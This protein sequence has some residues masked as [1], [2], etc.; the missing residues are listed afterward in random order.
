MKFEWPARSEMTPSDLKKWQGLVARLKWFV[1]ELTSASYRQSVPPSSPWDIP[2]FILPVADQGAAVYLNL[3]SLS[4]TNQLPDFLLP[5]ANTYLA[6]L[7]KYFSSLGPDG[8]WKKP[9]WKPLTCLSRF[10]PD[11]T[12]EEWDIIA[13]QLPHISVE[14]PDKIAFWENPA[15]MLAGVETRTTIGKYARRRLGWEDALDKLNNI[16][17]QE[18]SAVSSRVKFVD[19]DDLVGW[20]EVYRSESI[21]SCMNNPSH[22]VTEHDTYKCY[23]TSAHDL[24]D[25][26]LRLAWLLHPSDRENRKK[27][28][29]RA[30]VHDPTKAYV[31]VY[32]DDALTAGLEDLGYSLS[33]SWPE[34]LEL[35]AEGLDGDSDGRYSHPYIDGCLQRAEF[36]HLASGVGVWTLDSDGAYDLGHPDGS[37]NPTAAECSFCGSHM[38]D[39]H[40]AWDG[41]AEIE[42]CSGCYDNHP[43]AYYLGSHLLVLAD[44][45]SVV[46]NGEDYIND[47]RNLDYYDIV[48]SGYEDTYVFREDCAFVGS[49]GDYVYEEHL[50][51]ISYAVDYEVEDKVSDFEDILVRYSDLTDWTFGGVTYVIPVEGL[52]DEIDEAIA[53]FKAEITETEATEDSVA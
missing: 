20:E 40:P 39:T 9:E 33:D 44:E 18:T 41:E 8:Q 7:S 45:D 14:Q 52:S 53:N 21:Q 17:L 11:M 51:Y 13:Q 34:G 5:V 29:A 3:G 31:R 2:R 10:Q 26:G 47:S 38:R 22:G 35:F 6:G 16:H 43:V 4:E 25:N 32:G 42:V 49:I 50:V 24:P 23:A 28:V 36:D 37:I 19:N 1:Q 12:T 15:K 27:A 30:I 48:W 46:V